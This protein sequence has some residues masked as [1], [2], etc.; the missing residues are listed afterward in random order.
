MN[1]AIIT[2]PT[3][4]IGIAL[5]KRLLKENIGV[6]AVCHKG[7]VRIKDIPDSPLVNVVECDLNRL[8]E[9][10]V[11]LKNQDLSDAVFYHF[12][13]DGTFG[14]TRNNVEGQIK[15]IQF[16][17]DAVE[18][19]HSLGCKRFIGAGSQAEYG[20]VNPNDFP[21]LTSLTPTFPEN[22]YGIAK[23]CAGNMS[24]IKCEQL[25]MEHIWTRIL[26]VYGPHDGKNT[27]V[28]SMIR[29][30]QNGEHVSCTAG[31]Q[32]WDYL[33]ASDAG[34]AFYLLGKANAEKV[35]GNTYVI[36]SGEGKPLREYMDIIRDSVDACAELGVGEIP[37]ADKQ[38]MHLVADIS[39]LQRDTGFRPKVPYDEGIRYT[40][41]WI[42]EREA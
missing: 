23:L 24:R 32:M 30:L 39:E 31:E 22:G 29:K 38:V 20:R 25:G 37:Y 4:A 2:G 36:G 28:S 9:L 7:S 21:K 10:Q 17:I 18:V 19:A 12:G 3:G 35:N 11:I 13:W 8:N 6:T 26:S 41:K 5:I 33:Y 1:K 42:K 34:E 27:L 15:N 40:A 14:N 16:T